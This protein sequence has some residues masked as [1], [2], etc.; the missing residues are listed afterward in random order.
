VIRHSDYITHVGNPEDLD[1]LKRPLHDVSI[2]LMRTSERYRDIVQRCCD[3]IEW[4]ALT[5]KEGYKK[6]HGMS[7]ANAGVP[8]NIIGV[9]RERG[10]PGERVDIMLN[11]RVVAASEETFESLSNCGSLT[12]PEPIR[13]RR[14]LWVDVAWHDRGGFERHGRFGHDW[15]SM[16]GTVQHEID[17]NRGIL[18]TDRRC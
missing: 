4:L 16:T 12:L 18:I 15:R 3:Y 11:P 6:P 14:H 5:E 8:F 7:G 1:Y 17:H 13:V 10:R 2:R 9:V